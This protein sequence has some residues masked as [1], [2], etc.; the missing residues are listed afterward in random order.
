MDVKFNNAKIREFK[1][2]IKTDQFH[3]CIKKAQE[4]I[5]TEENQESASVCPYFHIYRNC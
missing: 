1:E 3:R 4:N 2:H 5:D